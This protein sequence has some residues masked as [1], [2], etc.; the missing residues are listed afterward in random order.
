MFTSLSSYI[1]IPLLYSTVGSGCTSP[2]SFLCFGA[3]CITTL[4]LASIPNFL[5]RFPGAREFS[6]R[7]G[8]LILSVS[9]EDS[10]TNECCKDWDAIDDDGAAFNVPTEDSDVAGEGDASVFDEM[11][12]EEVEEVIEE[13]GTATFDVIEEGMTFVLVVFFGLLATQDIGTR[14]GFLLSKGETRNCTLFPFL[15]LRPES[16]K[17]FLNALEIFDCLNFR[18]FVC[19]L[20]VVPAVTKSGTK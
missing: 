4:A 18:C 8:I 2:V 9:K 19:S 6:F 11:E 5:L 12:K 15:T 16:I 7:D 17:V 1:R 3:D 13:D 14:K 10:G 20:Y